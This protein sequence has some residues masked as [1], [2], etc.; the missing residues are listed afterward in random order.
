[1]A[2]RRW[3]E[4]EY[5]ELFG[6]YPPSGDRPRGDDLDRLARCLN[7]TRDSVDWQWQDAH[8]YCAGLSTTATP[9]LMRYLDRS[10]LCR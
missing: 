4:Q 2:G 5:V 7:R 10:G 9:V 3:T 6:A 8:R 1:V